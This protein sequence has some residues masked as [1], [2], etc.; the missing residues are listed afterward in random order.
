M[1]RNISVNTRLGISITIV[2][3]KKLGWR[4]GV[5]P[6]ILLYNASLPEVSYIY[7][8]S[9]HPLHR[10]RNTISSIPYSVNW[11]F[12]VSSSSSYAGSVIMGISSKLSSSSNL[13]L[14]VT[15]LCGPGSLNIS[16]ERMGLAA[17]LSICGLNDFPEIV[18]ETF[19]PFE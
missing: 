9:P 2:A 5:Y 11:K 4:V 14:A 1:Y 8:Q 12:A 3:A 16:P 15:L 18:D 13:A 7:I 19:L 6:G 17:G 10:R